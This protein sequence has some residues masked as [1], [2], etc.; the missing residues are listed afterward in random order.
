[1]VQR[2]WI[3]LGLTVPLA[4]LA[5]PHAALGAIHPQ[6]LFITVRCD[7]CYKNA[8]IWS[9]KNIVPWVCSCRWKREGLLGALSE[10]SS[11]SM[12]CIVANQGDYQLPNLF[13]SQENATYLSCGV[14][15]G[16]VK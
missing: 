11:S 4:V 16:I 13:I 1:M 8:E 7:S 5:N 6:V 14:R 12:S 2:Y 15:G 3:S 9:L 10:K